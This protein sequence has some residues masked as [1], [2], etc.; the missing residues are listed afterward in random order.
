MAGRRPRLGRRRLRAVKLVEELGLRTQRIEPLIRTLEEFSRRLDE[1]KCRIEE[2]KRRKLPAA[3][4]LVFR[5][6]ADSFG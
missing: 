2:H 4:P 5:A 1:L 6:L 3:A